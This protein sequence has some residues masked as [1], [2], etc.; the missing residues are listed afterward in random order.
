[1][2]RYRSSR[3]KDGVGCSLRKL[4]V[5][6]NRKQATH[7]VCPQR[8]ILQAHTERYFALSHREVPR[9]TWQSLP[10]TLVLGKQRKQSRIEFILGC[11]ATWRPAYAILSQTKSKPGMVAVFAF[12]PS[13]QETKGGGFLCVLGLSVLQS[14]F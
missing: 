11:I 9:Q 14:E 5:K 10:I 12:N 8:P 13:T 2:Q 3:K 6:R 1:V 7:V 4:A